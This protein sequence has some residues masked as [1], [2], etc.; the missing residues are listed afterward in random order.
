MSD[1]PSVRCVEATAHESKIDR[2]H[3]SPC[4]RRGLCISV[5]FCTFF[6][7]YRVRVSCVFVCCVRCVVS[8]FQTC[9]GVAPRPQVVEPVAHTKPLTDT[10]FNGHF[11]ERC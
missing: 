8:R 5:I 1:L 3:D 10:E 6:I 11:A 9:R 4:R 2:A 7:D